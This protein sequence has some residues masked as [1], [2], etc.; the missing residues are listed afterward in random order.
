MSKCISWHHPPGHVHFRDDVPDDA[1]CLDLGGPCPYDGER[2]N[3]QS[4]LRHFGTVL[5]IGSQHVVCSEGLHPIP[6]KILMLTKDRT[7]YVIIETGEKFD[8]LT[9][10]TWDRSL[11]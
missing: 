1:V 6:A 2:W 4:P 9:A 7:D 11:P 8:D 10:R 3:G 5:A